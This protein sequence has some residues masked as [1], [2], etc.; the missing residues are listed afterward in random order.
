MRAAGR[1]WAGVVAVVALGAATLGATAPSAGAAPGPPGAKQYYFDQWDVP[2]IWASGAR[3]QGVVIAELDTGVNAALPEFGDKILP[4][5]DVGAAGGDGRTDRDTDDFGHGTAMASIMV[6]NPG[7]YSITGL[8]PD[9]RILPVGIP[10]Q[11]TSDAADDDRLP[12]AIRWAADH[13]AKII[14]MSLGGERTPSKDPVPCPASEQEAVFHAMSKGAV[15]VAASGNDGRKGSPVADPGVCLG[16]VSVGA[17]D[18]DG[19]VAGFSS[20]HPYLTMS[21]P[22]VAIASLSKVPGSGYSGDATAITSAALAL[23]WSAHPDLD[24][25]GVVTRLLATLQPG[26]GQQ[27]GTHSNAYGYGT[28]AADRLVRDA[29]DA[30]ADN[31]IYTA[32]APFVARYDQSLSV[33]AAP[34]GPTAPAPPAAAIAP[35]DPPRLLGTPFWLACVVGVAGLLLAVA[36]LVLRRRL[37]RGRQREVVLGSGGAP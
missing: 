34:V 12:E 24:A 19:D 18:S 1:R 6:A 16:V 3:G 35:G 20:Q 22:G 30:D 7:T 9:A 5:L 17:V 10:L 21:A 13:G 36:A 32:A 26:K 2:G 28:L 33:R 25:K 8:A 4:G 23:A 15:L 37:G 31:P 29:V 27:A 11:G 14:S